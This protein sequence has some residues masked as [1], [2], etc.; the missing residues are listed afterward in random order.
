LLEF[1]GDNDDI[2][3]NATGHAE[4]D[5]WKWGDKQNAIDSVIR[6]KRGVYVSIL[7]EFS[8]VLERSKYS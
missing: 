4:F 6:F 1:L 8:D 3:L 2:N 5:A 7:D